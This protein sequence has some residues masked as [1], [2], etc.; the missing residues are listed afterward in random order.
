MGCKPTV[1]KSESVFDKLQTSIDILD[2]EKVDSVNCHIIHR[3]TK[4][5]KESLKMLK[6]IE[7]KSVTT[8]EL[9]FMIQEQLC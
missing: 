7:K 3:F 1:N 9:Y 6:T 2:I 4:N 8:G 5:L